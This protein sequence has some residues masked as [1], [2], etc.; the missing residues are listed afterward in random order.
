MS[1]TSPQSSFALAP[2]SRRRSREGEA[3]ELVLLLQFD[4]VGEFLVLVGNADKL[5]P[6][7][8][9]PDLSR[10][11]PDVRRAIAVILCCF[12]LPPPSQGRLDYCLLISEVTKG[13]RPSH[14]IAMCHV[15]F[16]LA[17]EKS[18]KAKR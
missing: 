15:V 3:L 16:K 18:E 4:H 6:K 10:F 12:Q 11:Q 8:R 9:Q 13:T 1:R 7:V 2:M 5:R 17:K 14:G